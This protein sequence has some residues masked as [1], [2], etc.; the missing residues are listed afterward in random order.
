M[1][2]KK[3][4]IIDIETTGGLAR[5]DKIT[6]IGIVI[7]DGSKIVGQYESLINPGRSIPYNIT[8]ITGITDA[9]VAD[10]PK[11]YEVAK[12]VVEM[13]EGAIFVAHN[14][15]FDYSFIKEAF[16]NLGYTYS[17][18]QLDTVRLARKSFP[19]LKSYSLGNL[20]KHFGIKV[21]SRH[22]ALA[23]ALATTE[24]LEMILQK[25]NAEDNINL[26]INH[27][28]RESQLPNAITMDTLHNL[29]EECGVYYL[30]NAYGK[31][32]YIGKSINIKKRVIQHFSKTT[33][34]AENLQKQVNS[35]DYEL[36]GSEL[37]SLLLE[38]HEIKIHQPSINKI[39]RNAYFPYFIHHYKDEAG[40]IRFKLE[41]NSN[42]RRK[43]KQIL[44]DYSGLQ[45]S[46]AHLGAISKEYGLCNKLNH[47]EEKDGPCFDYKLQN[48]FGACI[49]EED[50]ESYN[51][52]AEMAIS[53]LTRIFTD[54]FI[55]LDRGRN[56]EE[57]AVILVEEGYYKGYGYATKEDLDHG[58]EE[59]KET[60][61]Y[62]PENPET[63]NIV[64]NYMIDYPELKVIKFS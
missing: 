45:S 5:R 54:D 10:A 60:I 9:M 26:F 2:Q 20:I 38:S 25:E 59:I 33:R 8:R 13:T 30:K 17:K 56:E 57:M 7:Y 46:K 52:R 34:K 35:I 29:P 42:K 63:N 49:L 62:V 21:K 28:L 4:A 6:E 22:R 24:L 27:G 16:K 14:V 55:L 51:L 19:G 3:Y 61:K 15:R 53:K 1:K 23:D 58:I 41:K 32:V 31:I 44:S 48:C 11:F 50:A 39:Q 18:R 40:Y 43:D 64:R 36:T 37:V 12:T 47:L